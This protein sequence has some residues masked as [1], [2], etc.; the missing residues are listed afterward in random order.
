MAGD[1]PYLTWAF[2]EDLILPQN[3]PQQVCLQNP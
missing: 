3:A 2:L 1:Q